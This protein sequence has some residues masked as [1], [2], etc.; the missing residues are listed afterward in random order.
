MNLNRVLNVVDMGRNNGNGQQL[1]FQMIP[2][3]MHT[4]SQLTLM[5]AVETKNSCYLVLSKIFGHN[6]KE[7][8]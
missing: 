2:A 5:R 3:F 6:G 7:F 4:H 8:P 1:T